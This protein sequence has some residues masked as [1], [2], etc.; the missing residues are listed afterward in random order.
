MTIEQAE[1]IRLNEQNRRDNRIWPGAEHQNGTG[2]TIVT[3]NSNFS[4]ETAASLARF[5]GLNQTGQNVFLAGGKFIGRIKSL[6]SDEAGQVSY[7]VIHEAHHWS[8]NKIAPIGLVSE[9]NS[10]GLSLSFNLTKFQGLPD[11]KTDASITNEIESALWN[12]EVLRFTD[13]HEVDVQVKNGIVSL[14]GHITGTGNRER[15]ENA[16]GSVGGILAVR[17]DL[18]SDFDLLLKVAQALVE[19]ERVDGNHVLANVQNGLVVLNGKVISPHDRSLA[20]QCAANVP[21]VRGVINHIAAPGIDPEA[22]DQRFLQPAIGEK[23][24]F[25]DGQ[26]ATVKQVIINPNN[27]RVVD[28]VL[29]GQFPAYQPKPSSGTTGEPP[30]PDKLVVIPVSVIQYL[31]NSSGFLL[32][33]STQTTKYQDFNPANFVAPQPDWLPPYPYCTDNIRFTAE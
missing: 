21:S 4:M 23:I 25:H 2:L 9:I 12:D 10:T 15:I 24:Y 7:L 27:R 14:T 19:V 11:Y 29:K 5:A 1:Q 8:H 31:T 13:Y 16:V 22:E 20:E 18:V 28:M 3:D 30:P 26:F 33:D 17:N 6:L 32:I